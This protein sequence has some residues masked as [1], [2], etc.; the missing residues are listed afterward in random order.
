MGEDNGRGI[1]FGTGF[2]VGIL[3]GMLIAAWSLYWFSFLP[4]ALQH[5]PVEAG[6]AE[7]YI[8]ADG[9]KAFRWLPCEHAEE[10]D[11]E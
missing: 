8:D 11:G 2:F 7:W 10:V 3:G 5:I 9:D 1:F 6:A 4:R